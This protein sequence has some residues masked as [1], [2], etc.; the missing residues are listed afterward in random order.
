MLEKCMTSIYWVHQNADNNLGYGFNVIDL[1]CK[2][3]N[4]NMYISTKQNFGTTISIKIPLSKEDDHPKYLE[5]KTVEYISNRFSNIYVSIS[6]ITM[7][8]YI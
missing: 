3:F 2:A 6:L 7:I 8:N 1:F 5:S 4:A